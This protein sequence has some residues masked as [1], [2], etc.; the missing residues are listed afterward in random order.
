[1]SEDFETVIAVHDYYDGPRIGVANFDGLPHRFRSFG[2]LANGEW[3]EGSFNSDDDRYF[4]APVDSP[5]NHP[6]FVAPANFGY[7]NPF[8]PFRPASFVR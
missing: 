4:L 3:G 8:P 7:A 1:M 6:E 5:L 2:W